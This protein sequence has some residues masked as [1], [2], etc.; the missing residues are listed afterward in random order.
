VSQSHQLH[1]CLEQLGVKIAL[2]LG[3]SGLKL[4][5]RLDLFFL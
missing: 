4:F 5:P 1:L 2:L 3:D